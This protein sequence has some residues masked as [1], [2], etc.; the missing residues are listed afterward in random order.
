MVGALGWC[1]WRWLTDGSGGMCSAEVHLLGAGVSQD[2]E[3]EN[4]EIRV[5]EDREQACGRWRREG[6]TA[7]DGCRK[8]ALGMF[9]LWRGYMGGSGCSGQGM[10]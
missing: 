5:A 8:H 7:P 4:P 10:P 1:L 6:V 3:R 2:G 9:A